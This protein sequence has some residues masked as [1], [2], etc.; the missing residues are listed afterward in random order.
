[1][2]TNKQKTKSLRRAKHIVMALRLL[3]GIALVILALNITGC[4]TAFNQGFASGLSNQPYSQ[5]ASFQRQQVFINTVGSTTT[6]TS[7]GN[8]QTQTQFINTVPAVHFQ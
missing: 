3:A 7:I 2:K 8:G 6:V 4:T 1:M 5:Q